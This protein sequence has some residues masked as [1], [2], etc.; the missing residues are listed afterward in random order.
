MQI[1]DKENR[2]IHE[3]L[4]I[5]GNILFSCENNMFD[6]DDA[7]LTNANLFGI[8]A[9]GLICMGTKFINANL[10]GADLYMMMACYSDFTN[11]NLVNADLC[12]SNCIGTIF[13]GAN[14]TNANLGKDNIGGA[15]RL[16]EANLTQI[17][18]DGIILQE[19]EY[20]DKTIFPEGLNPKDYGM[21][22]VN[23]EDNS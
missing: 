1:F 3:I 9:E 8:I 15:V 7:D 13:R 18:F 5:Y 10:E 23:M 21:K 2:V 19:A 12:G 16:Q 22:F 17:K 11:A 20:D 4:D 14:L 6:L